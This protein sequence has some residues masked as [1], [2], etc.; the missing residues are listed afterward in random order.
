MHSSA[1][2]KLNIHNICPP[3][4]LAHT[5]ANPL[6]MLT[7]ITPLPHAT[8]MQQSLPNTMAANLPHFLPPCTHSSQYL[9]DKTLYEFNWAVAC[10]NVKGYKDPN[11]TSK[12]EVIWV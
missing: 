6:N 5:E 4:L 1:S 7:I 12:T 10:P 3:S 8:H 2:Q 11:H 9:R